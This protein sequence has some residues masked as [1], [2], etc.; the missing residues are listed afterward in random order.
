MSESEN[1]EE[2]LPT[3]GT[4]HFL[5]RSKKDSTNQSKN[6]IGTVTTK[7]VLHDNVN[8]KYLYNFSKQIVRIEYPGLVKNINSAIDTLGKMQEIEMVIVNI[9]T[10][11]CVLICKIQS[12]NVLF[13][14]CKH[15]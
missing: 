10:V 11:K 13:N 14:Y 2:W 4:G 12:S 1:D 7:S 6:S 8:S 15:I 5:K 3:G 9:F